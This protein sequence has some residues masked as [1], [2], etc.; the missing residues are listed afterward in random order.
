MK[1]GRTI[2]YLKFNADL[3]FEVDFK[4]NDAIYMISTT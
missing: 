2:E 1:H 3:N 4:V